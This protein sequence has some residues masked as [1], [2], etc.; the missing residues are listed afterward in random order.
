MT[1]E[2]L[3]ALVKES[4]ATITD[5][6]LTEVSKVISVLE[7]KYEARI[8]E[9]EDVLRKLASSFQTGIEQIEHVD[10]KAFYTKILWGIYDSN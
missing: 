6:N 9:F 5:E 1:N 3:K 8:S 7:D 10:P 4:N 2:E